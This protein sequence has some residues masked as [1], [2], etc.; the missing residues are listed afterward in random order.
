MPRPA[1]MMSSASLRPEPEASGCG[2]DVEPLHLAH[3]PAR[4]PAQRDASEG[5]AI[6]APRDQERTGWRRIFAGQPG[7]L[8]GETLIGEIDVERGRIFLEQYPHGS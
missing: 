8:I 1:W 7:Q 4:E 3:R 2:T 6:V 5:I